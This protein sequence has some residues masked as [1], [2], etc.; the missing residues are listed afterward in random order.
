MVRFLLWARLSSGS[1]EQTLLMTH[2]RDLTSTSIKKDDHTRF[3][4]FDRKFR[5]RKEFIQ[6]ARRVNQKLACVFQL[7]HKTLQKK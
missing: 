5:P 1:Y 4:E 3:M 6:K 2:R 7:R